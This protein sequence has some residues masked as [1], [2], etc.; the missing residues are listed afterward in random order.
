LRKS[1][2][3]GISRVVIRTREYLSATF[4]RDDALI[5]MLLRFPQEIR[6]AAKLELPASDDKE[7]QPAK[8]EMDLAMRLIDDM[9]EDWEPEEYHDEYRAALMDFIERKVS[10]G[11]SVEDVKQ[12]GKEDR[13]AD[14]D[15]NILDLADYLERSIKKE[16]PAPK[17][18][19]KPKPAARKTAKKDAAKK[20][21]SRKG[22][23]SA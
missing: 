14:S 5:L 1:N 11:E 3:A 16:K 17:K 4:V 20:S 15:G 23:K 9:T 7:F 18:T 19:T 13:K 12:G 22:R 2:K 6:S 8:K 21:T 10:R